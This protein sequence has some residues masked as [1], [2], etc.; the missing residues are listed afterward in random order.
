MCCGQVLQKPWASAQE[1][2]DEDLAASPSHE[3]M[4]DYVRWTGLFP[5]HG[6][7]PGLG[8]RSLPGHE[9]IGFGCGVDAGEGGD[10]LALT[11]P[12]S[13]SIGN[14]GGRIR[15]FIRGVKG[16]YIFETGA[17]VHGT[18]DEGRCSECVRRK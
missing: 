3:R 12:R 17:G 6:S 7:V 1:G 10:Q 18:I 14:L 5:L 4:R 15:C 11:D 8:F 16:S 2:S 13:D 9:T